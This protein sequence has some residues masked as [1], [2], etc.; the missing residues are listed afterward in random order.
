MLLRHLNACLRCITDDSM[1]LQG[2]C[3]QT[4][5]LCCTAKFAKLNDTVVL[6]QVVEW[7]LGG[8]RT[9]WQS[10]AFQ[11]ALDSPAAF[12]SHYISLHAD[13]AGQPE[14]CLIAH[15]LSSF[16]QY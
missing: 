6:G 8:V 1:E 11:A 12:V 9:E 2:K 14:V 13:A 5:L 15:N 4:L 16:A 7:V 3:T 10:P